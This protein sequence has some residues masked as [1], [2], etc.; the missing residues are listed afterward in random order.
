MSIDEIAQI[1]DGKLLNKSNTFEIYGSPKA[2]DNNNI[3]VKFKNFKFINSDKKLIHIKK[4]SNLKKANNK[5]LD[6]ITDCVEKIQDEKKNDTIITQHLAEVL[7]KRKIKERKRTVKKEVHLNLNN[8]NNNEKGIHKVFSKNSQSSQ[9]TNNPGKTSKIKAKF[10]STRN[11]I[12]LHCQN[13][14]SLKNE[15]ILKNE[16]NNQ[17]NNSYE[18]FERKRTNNLKRLKTSRFAKEKEKEIVY[19]ISESL[20]SLCKPNKKPVVKSSFANNANTNNNKGKEP[21]RSKFKGLKRKNSSSS[22]NI[23]FLKLKNKRNSTNKRVS[24]EER[25]LSNFSND[26]VIPKKPQ[27]TKKFKTFII[28]NNNKIKNKKN[29]RNSANTNKLLNESIFHLGSDSSISVNLSK[30]PSKKNVNIAEEGKKRRSNFEKHNFLDWTKDL[31]NREELTQKELVHINKDLIQSLI[32]YDKN[33]LEEEMKKIENTE[34]TDLVKHLPTIKNGKYKKKSFS[35]ERFEESALMNI[36]VTEININNGIKIDKERF[37]ILQHTG[38]VYDSLDDEEIEDAI[39]INNYYIN[40]DSTFIYIFDS[41]IAFL[42]FFI[43]FYSPLYLAHDS[44]SHLPFLNIKIIFFYSIDILYII[45][46]VIS[47]FRAYYNYDEILIKNVYEMSCHYIKNWFI[48]DFMAAIPFYSIF[49][50]LEN[51]NNKNYNKIYSSNYYGVKID[52]MHYLLSINKLLKIFKC[53]SD[54]NRA[55]TYLTNILFQSNVIEEKSGIFFVIFILLVTINFGTCIFIFIGRNSYPG[56]MHTK[57]IENESFTCI[58]ICSLYYLITTITTVGYGDIYGITIKEISFQIILLI[59]GTCTYSYLIS[60]VSNFIKKINEKSIIFENKLKILNDIRLTNP[61]LEEQL[62]DKILRFLRYKKMTEKNKHNIIINSLP[63]S[64]KNSLII[65]MYKPI[66]NNFIIFK[67]LENSNCIVQLVTAFK[68]IYSIKNDILIQEGDFIEEVIF[69]KAGIISLEIGIDFNKPKESIVKYLD[70]ISDKDNLTML[71]KGNVGKFDSN[72]KTISS[73]STFLQNAKKTIKS[74]KIEN[75]N[76]H[77]LKVLDIRKNEHFGETL[78]FLNER[79]FLTA[80]VKSKKAELF[81]LKK[82][83][84]IRIFNAFPNIWNRINKRSIYNMRQIKITVKRVLMNFCS[85]WGIN[86]PNNKEDTK[87]KKLSLST[88][89][90]RRKSEKS[91]IK[92]NENEKEKEKESEDN[93]KSSN[94]QSN[95][96]NE[97]LGLSL[98]KDINLNLDEEKKTE[99][100]KSPN[101]ENKIRGEI[102]PL[103][104]MNNTS[105]KNTDLKYLNKINNESMSLY[106]KANSFKYNKYSKSINFSPIGTNINNSKNFDSNI[107]N[108]QIFK[109]KNNYNFS[110]F[111]G[112]KILSLNDFYNE[113]NKNIIEEGEN[114]INKDNN[115]SKETVKIS[116]NRKACSLIDSES[117]NDNDL[118]LTNIQYDVND[119]IYK[120]EIF[121]LHLGKETDL[122]KNKNINKS[123]LNNKVKIDNLSRKILEKTW[124]KNLDKEKMNYLDQ[125]LNKSS[126]KNILD[127]LNKNSF[128]NKSEK[129][130]H[131]SFSSKCFEKTDSESFE[132]KSSYEN[133]NEITGNKYIKNSI[134][135]NRTKEFLLKECGC[136]LKEDKMNESKLSCNVNFNKSMICEKKINRNI[137]KVEKNEKVDLNKSE[138]IPIRNMDKNQR[139][140][141]GLGTS[142]R[143]KRRISCQRIPAFN[144]FEKKKPHLN[145]FKSDKNLLNNIIISGKSPKNLKFKSNKY[146]KMSFSLQ[147]NDFL[148]NSV[149]LKDENLSFYDKYNININTNNENTIQNK[150]TIKRRKRVQDSQLEE[151]NNII[152]K[153][154]QNLN[155]PALYYQQLFFNQIQKKKENRNTR[156]QSNKYTLLPMNRN[157]NENNL[158]IAFNIK[159]TSTE[160]NNIN[161]ML[162]YSLKN[163]L[164]TSKF[165]KI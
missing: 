3:D 90:K 2:K 150:Q 17:N 35:E 45:D 28:K 104:I 128:R 94:N 67:G 22:N 146:Q 48:V 119:E 154:A 51:L 95:V 157:K 19:N 106:S 66:I 79:S 92:E 50:F 99:I 34:T 91:K 41:I 101:S 25:Y 44:F 18:D 124:I 102:S 77:Y 115:D 4:K 36:N 129:S 39:E 75:K 130:L 86:L 127:A 155:Q 111:K 37:R 47:F 6:F 54:N 52:K 85:M 9:R 21:E 103:E 83:E 131:S 116:L 158:K 164:V 113:D 140:S 65:E 148:N 165:K 137:N 7:E 163:N 138:I 136:K 112:N 118:E 30:H 105:Y 20:I 13:L 16:T 15:V 38:Y 46:L 78:M 53:F 26:S 59:L 33:K 107:L 120:N 61:H 149:A 74:D 100:E 161:K 40:P 134:L 69:V 14:I 121:D 87:K 142:F 32:G 159:R 42:S 23:K 49:N 62:Y 56:W 123:N 96:Q 133:I 55:L 117:L 82:E 152:Q 8:I 139:I 72:I 84:V 144:N 141:K 135:R 153:D 114:E 93:E 98:S 43:I 31:K 64:L 1:D 58:Y 88:L 73:T 68:P 81:F 132:I 143:F 12:C 29:H 97:T 71:L 110:C 108:D 125:M 160:S 145:S 76:T 126:D 122:L 60:S 162:N 89:N 5:I 109:L 156:P 27:K 10:R 151:I 11:Q 80:K 70:R 24:R 63:Y 147:N 57:R